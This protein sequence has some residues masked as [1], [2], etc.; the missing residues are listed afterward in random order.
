MDE[1]KSIQKYKP[2]KEISTKRRVSNLEQKRFLHLHPKRNI[3]PSKGL[4]IIRTLSKLWKVLLLPSLQ[5]SP[6][7]THPILSLY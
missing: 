4:N 6:K 7:T 5:K 2:Q 1:N 3:E